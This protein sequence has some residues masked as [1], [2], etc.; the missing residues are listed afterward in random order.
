MVILLIWSSNIKTYVLIVFFEGALQFGTTAIT[1]CLLG[2]DIF[3]NILL[4]ALLT[5]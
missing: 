2:C 3:N 5:V 4:I 1:I